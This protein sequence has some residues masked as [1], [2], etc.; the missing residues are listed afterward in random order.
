MLLEQGQSLSDSLAIVNNLLPE[1]TMIAI[2]VAEHTGALNQVL[3]EEAFRLMDRSGQQ[4]PITRSLPV[5]ISWMVVMGIA[6]TSIVSFVM[7]YI[8]PKFKRIFED[9]GTELPAPTEALIDLADWMLDY[10][11][12]FMLPVVTSLCITLFFALRS[13]YWLISKGHL[14]YSEHVP[15]YWTPM[16]LR[17]LSVTTATGSTIRESLHMVLRDLRP[18]RAAT[19]ISALRQAIDSGQDCWKAMHSLGLLTHREALFLESANKTNHVDWGMQHLAATLQRRRSVWQSRIVS[20]I[21]PLSILIAGSAIGTIC[22]AMFLPLIKLVN[23]L[24]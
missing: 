12:L 14:I 15:R 1:Q 3:T 7:V 13:Q 4:S 24:S 22:I 17:L 11:Y 10:W 20:A 2:R 16:L 21:V 8:I 5:V 23:D 18:G 19:R 6:V 9:F